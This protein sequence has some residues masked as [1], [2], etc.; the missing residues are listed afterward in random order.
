MGKKFNEKIRMR[1]GHVV[2]KINANLKE[3][4]VEYK[5]KSQAGV[6]YTHSKA[7]LEGSWYS[8]PN[9]HGRRSQKSKDRK[10]LIKKTN[11]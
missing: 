2:K 9:R 4:Y 3:K 7:V 6:E 5:T 8:T 1:R 10:P 11:K